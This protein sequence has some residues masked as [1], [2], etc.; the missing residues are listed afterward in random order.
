MTLAR[1]ARR[2][3]GL[4]PRGWIG[5]VGVCV[6]SIRIERS[7]RLDSLDATARRFGSTLSFEPPPTVADEL[8]ISAEE[9][10]RVATA[11]AVLRRGPFNST[12]LR[13]ALVI[14]AELQHY[15][16][17]LRV[18]IAKNSGVVT[19]HAWTEVAGLAL[20]PMADREFVVPRQA[21]RE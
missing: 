11:L 10:A 4:G 2:V 18:G 3:V 13:R 6:L 14:G 20:D 5:A 17:V 1:T 16:P 9:R 7:L 8:P 15:A 12:C 19:A 21:G